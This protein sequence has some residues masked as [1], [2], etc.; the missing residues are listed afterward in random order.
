MIEF[1]PQIRLV[2]IAAVAA[3]GALFFLRGAAVQLGAQW[4]MAAPLR[5]LS[6]TIDTVLLTAALMLATILH[7]YP[8]VDTWLTVKVL[9]LATYIVLGV[10]ALRRGRTPG[11]RLASWL[12]ALDIFGLIVS[13][14][15]TR[16]PLGALQALTT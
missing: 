4:A 9:L 3:S 12:A 15:R 1:Y 5:Y 8:F 2:H 7:Q 6:Y 14:A 13:V 10:L 11:I 16:H